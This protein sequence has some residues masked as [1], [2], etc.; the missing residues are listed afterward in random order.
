MLFACWRSDNALSQ[1]CLPGE[2]GRILLG[3]AGRETHRALSLYPQGLCSAGAADLE[4]QSWQL[5][6]NRNDTACQIIKT[7]YEGL[8]KSLSRHPCN[9]QPLNDLRIEWCYSC[10]P[11]ESS[12]ELSRTRF[13]PILGGPL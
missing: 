5:L 7:D 8:Q 10:S 4:V 2:V 1:L 12:F 9:M 11:A 13:F 6:V 3:F